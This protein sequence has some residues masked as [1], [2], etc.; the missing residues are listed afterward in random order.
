MPGKPLP[1]WA[2]V[3][4]REF[5]ERVR[6]V[7]F[8]V[9][10]LLGPIGMAAVIVLPAWLSVKSAEKEV[11]IQ[12]V[13]RT[14]EDLAHWMN[15]AVAA[16][17]ANYVIEPVPD[18]KSE[19][20][21]EEL[22]KE[23]RKRIANETIDGYLI[24]PK[25]ALDGQPARYFGINATSQI[26]K[27]N[28]TRI[29]SYAVYRTRAE[30]RHIDPVTFAQLVAPVTVTT[31]LDNGVTEEATSGTASF[32]VGYAV[33]F[34]LYM[35]I[36]LYAVNVMRSVVMEKTSRVVEIMV[37]SIKPRAL[38]LGKILG[39]GGV[40]LFQLSIWAAI[41][42]I[43]LRFREQV[44][45]LFGVEGAG[46]V[47]MPSLTVGAIALVLAYF[48]LGYFFYSSLYAAIGAMVSSE[49]EA[50]QAQTPIVLLLV[51]PVVCV[52]LVSSDPRSSAAEILTLIPFSSPVLM[53]MRYLLGGATTTDVALSLAIL[54]LATW[55]AVFVAARIYR[56]GILMYGKRPSLRELG[57][58]IR[59]S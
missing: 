38:M 13:D 45:G 43:L 31:K 23:L 11:H 22:R 32:I 37:S 12:M 5:V 7:W 58:W 51:I 1:E 35:A 9:V 46:S 36:L 27:I 56:I 53:P 40:G 44:L 54:V 19:A 57:R 20:E 26:L 30:Q 21:Q 17:G 41:A 6:T 24:V 55:L 14:G 42:L 3:A 52:Q 49:Q 50:Q 29:V 18:A 48:L 39:V 34:I 2:V 28:L 10:T 25:D 4:R 8:I 15:E 16:V 47:A 33:M 59:H